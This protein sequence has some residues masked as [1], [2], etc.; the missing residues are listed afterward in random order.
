ML[1]QFTLVFLGL[2]GLGDQILE[3]LAEAFASTDP[4]DRLLAKPQLGRQ[5]AFMLGYLVATIYAFY[6]RAWAWAYCIAPSIA[7]VMVSAIQHMS[8]SFEIVFGQ[9]RHDAVDMVLGACMSF[10]SQTFWN[11]VILT[12]CYRSRVYLIS[13]FRPYIERAARNRTRFAAEFIAHDPGPDPCRR[14]EQ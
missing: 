8:F 3:T 7:I 1:L 4:V 12:L 6:G 2:W 14:H 10:I 9:W 11:L 13:R 5:T